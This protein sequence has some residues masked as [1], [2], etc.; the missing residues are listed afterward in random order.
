MN[1]DAVNIRS[2]NIPAELK[3]AI[4]DHLYFVQGKSTELATLHDWYMAVAYTVRDRMMKNWIDS[5]QHLHDKGRKIVCYLSAEFLVGP[6]LG[7]ALINLGIE[8]EINEAVEQLG[9]SLSQILE[10]EDEPG[11]GN[12]GLG[13]LAACYL[14]SLTTLKVPAIGYGIR[15]EFGI[16]DQKIQNGWQ[17]EQTD[18]WLRYGNPW[19]IARPEVC[20]N[21]KLRGHTENYVDEKDSQ[22]VKWVPLYEVKG[23]A[24]DTPVPG[25]KNQAV[26][27]LRLWKSEAIESFD[28]NAFN[29]ADY[30]EAVDQKIFSETISKI[31]YP[32][33][34]PEKGKRLRLTQ[35]YFFVSCSLRDTIRIQFLR[36]LS[37]DEL[38]ESFALQLNDT[39]PSIAV[40]ELMRI[41][42]DEYLVDWDRAW[43]ITKNTLS[44]TNHTLLPEALEKWSLPLF[45]SL[46]PRHLEIIYEI[47]AR[48]LNEIKTKY[49]GDDQ[50]VKRLSIIDE[51]GNKYV[52]MAH[53]ACIGGHA[54]NGVS[55]LHTELL[56]QDVLH[57]FYE[58]EPG[59]FF[60][61][62]NVVTPRRWI[63]L[64]NPKLADLI[65]AKIGE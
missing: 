7:N 16:F 45:A 31:L 30:Y 35:Q 32:N 19:E 34:E 24:Y 12:G 2:G 51:E 1:K 6:H 60:N 65:T 58:L 62:T 56:K 15:Y 57:D 13:R 38:P 40:A 52:R 9:R 26:N 21:V 63:K 42:I 64:Y 41:L 11:L 27:I 39:H 50:M 43:N 61:I 49:N 10:V 20:Y 37:I 18:K 8:N 54:V 29:K 25:Y 3:Q 55:A 36:E 5:L 33:D 17:V 48:F 47:N 4:L 59:K 28:F 44:Y 14:D 53:L 22:R 46:L 23:V